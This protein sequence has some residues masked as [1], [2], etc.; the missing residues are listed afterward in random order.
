MLPFRIFVF[1]LHLCAFFVRRK[2]DALILVEKVKLTKLPM[3]C[4]IASTT[5]QDKEWS[6]HCVFYFAHTLQLYLKVLKSE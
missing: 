5:H 4:L 1:F 2:S 6:I 3:A